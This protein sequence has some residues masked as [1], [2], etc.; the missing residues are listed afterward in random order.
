MI[1]ATHLPFLGIIY[2]FER[3][4]LGPKSVAGFV[5]LQRI[6][7]FETL[8]NGFNNTISGKVGTVRGG[9]KPRGYRRESVT[10]QAAQQV[11][12]EVFL[13]SIRG[14]SGRNPMYGTVRSVTIK[15]RTA[16]WIQGIPTPMLQTRSS[17]S[18]IQLNPPI[19]AVSAPSEAEYD[20]SLNPRD[21]A[22]LRPRRVSLASTVM[23]SDEDVSETTV[24]RKTSP[25][26]AI[27]E[28]ADGDDEFDEVNAMLEDD[29]LSDRDIRSRALNRSRLAPPV[30][31][32]A[33]SLIQCNSSNAGK[34]LVKGRQARSPQRRHERMG[35]ERKM[36]NKADTNVVD[37]N[38]VLEKLGRL[39]KLV[40][41]LSERLEGHKQS[42]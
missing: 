33:E 26:A 11:L 40:E 36:D 12:D 38:L 3:F 2:C 28:D 4:Y 42:S 1:K 8:A 13:S 14:P 17:M 27:V 29:D 41:S 16:D 18:Q 7:S 10:T 20:R 9:G 24:D 31:K 37:V 39:E 32:I 5:P 6:S 25:K 34:Q 21:A 15:P 35:F 19:L 30:G 22:T 23:E